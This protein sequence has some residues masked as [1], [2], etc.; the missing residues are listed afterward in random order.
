MGASEGTALRNIRVVDNHGDGILLGPMS[1]MVSNQA[2]RNNR[3]I[4]VEC[5]SSIT[6]NAAWDNETDN[7]KYIF[8]NLCQ[9]DSQHNSEGQSAAACPTELADCDGAGVER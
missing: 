1:V 8:P 9:A 7:L 3:G 2:I 4:V 5:P 6:G